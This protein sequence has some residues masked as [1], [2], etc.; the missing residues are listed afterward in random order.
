MVVG[1]SRSEWAS[2]NCLD[3]S[4][5]GHRIGC[6]GVGGSECPTV[7]REGADCSGWAGW[8]P[9]AFTAIDVLALTG[10]QLLSTD[11]IYPLLIM[12]LLPVLVGLDVSSRRAT[13]G[14]GPHA[15]RVRPSRCFKTRR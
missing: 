7:D 2:A 4:V 11:G 1:T 6:A 14:A 8:K 12:T 10:F 15:R 13:V 9:F 3:R 5:R